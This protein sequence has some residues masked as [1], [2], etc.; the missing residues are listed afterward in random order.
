[1]VS[2]VSDPATAGFWLATSTGAVV[3]YNGAPDYGDADLPAAVVGMAATGDG[4]GYL[5]VAEDGRAAHLGDPSGPQE[6]SGASPVP[7][8][9]LA[10]TPSGDGYWLAATDGD[11]LA[12]G[13]AGEVAPPPGSPRVVAI[14]AAPPGAAAS[15]L[16]AGAPAELSVTTTSLPAPVAGD[17]YAAQL[18]ASGGTSPYSWRV[19]GGALPPGLALSATG[20]ISGTAGP[21]LSGP[22]DL[23][24]EVTDASAPSPRHATADITI[25]GSPIANGSPA[26]TQVPL[27]EVHSQ[28]WSGYV[29]TPGP[30]TA[31]AGD[32]TVPS[33]SPAAGGQDMMS[34][35][36]GIDGSDNTS[37]VQAGVTEAPDP[38]STAGFDVFAWW[39]VLPAAGQPIKAVTV[40]AGDE[41][42][43][44][45]AQV[46]GTSWAIDLTD[47]TNGQAYT[48]D[49]SYTGPGASAEWI[50]EAP[51]DSQT[52][53]QL[54]LAPFGPAV[55]FSGLSATGGSTTMS[56]VTMAQEGQEVSAPS[57][58]TT[59]GFSV[60]YGGAA[61]AGP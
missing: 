55:N 49:V 51:T 16:T 2:I 9:G 53:Q 42:N 39:E 24:V 44:T 14:V 26:L 1:V 43:V 30:Y 17:A 12:Y 6:L 58:L 59:S 38:G 20:A 41:V 11:V 25:A 33:L 46:S 52:G 57:A 21:G 60:T 13:G 50:L 36:V 47:I 34:E 54:P 7:V 3:G 23:T 19:L 27:S 40:S 31:A 37:L 32:F 10:A 8:V 4:R 56:E 61:P 5:V 48:Q 35:W 22:F 28:N 45:I 15:A 29:A 18:A